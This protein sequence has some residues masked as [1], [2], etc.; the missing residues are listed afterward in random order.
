MAVKVDNPGVA[1]VHAAGLADMVQRPAARAAGRV[2][3]A[4]VGLGAFGLGSLAFVFVR[5]LEAWHITPT[6]SAHHLTIFG[7]RLS[8]PTA[9]LDAIVV[10]GLALLAVI[11][12]IRALRQTVSEARW[13]AHVGR[14]L[15][16]SCRGDH[17][18][19]LL[20]G[21]DEPLAF[22]A[23]LLRPRVYVSAGAVT[24]LD[25]AALNA[26]LEH[27]RHHARHRDPLRLAVGRVLGEALFFVPGL[28]VLARRHQALAELGAD[29]GAVRAAPANRSALARAM[30]GFADASSDRGGAGFDP[31]RVDYLLGD[32]PTWGFPVL[33]CLS[34][35]AVIAMLL[36]VAL[37]AGQVAAGSATLAPPVLARQP[38]IAT[39]AGIPGAL[40]LIAACCGRRAGAGRDS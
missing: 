10:L 1:S 12:T 19:A 28:R 9:N 13:A 22:C 30:L 17:N 35:T 25:E 11:A 3:C 40:V 7:Q 14:E 32:P 24:L 27:E 31:A 33:L 2:F 26:V 15:K 5:L 8:Y 36:A 34:A 23:G 20:T 21:D 18:G 37:L 39:L 16:R 6:A 29:E 38:C 4:R